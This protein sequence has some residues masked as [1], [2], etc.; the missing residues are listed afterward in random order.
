MMRDVMK[1]VLKDFQIQKSAVPKY[2]ITGLAFVLIFYMIGGMQNQMIFSVISFILIYRFINTALYED[3]KNN[4]LRLL[5]SLPVR[6][7]IIV[8]ARYVS[9]GIFSIALAAIMSI[10][11]ALTGMLSGEYLAASF[12]VFSSFLF[13][14][15]MISVYMPLGFKLGYF[16]AVNVN[17]FLFFAIFVLFAAIPLLLG[18]LG[19]GEP[20]EFAVRFGAML[21]AMEPSLVMAGF[22]IFALLVYIVSMRISIGFFRKRMLF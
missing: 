12:V 3:E 6:R 19:G 20:P 7:D 1:L 4:S 10:V 21:E 2:V 9:T 13:F 22:A 14:M 17:R 8:I 15:I 11:M 5:A 16:K 18:R